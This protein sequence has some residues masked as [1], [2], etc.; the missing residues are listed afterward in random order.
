MNTRLL[1]LEIPVGNKMHKA[2]PLPVIEFPLAEE[3]PTASEES[4]HCQKKSEATAV[5]ITLLSKVK[6]KLDSYEVPKSTTTT[7]TTSGETGTK[8]GRTVT[9]TAED[10][11]KKKNDVKARTTLLLS[12]PDEHQLHFSKYKTARELWAAILKTFGGNEATKKTKKNL[13]KQQYGNFRAEGS[14]TLEQTFTRLQFGSRMA[15]AHYSRS[16]LDTMSLDD[17][18]NHLKVYESEVHKKSEPNYQIMAFISLAKHSS[19]S[20]D[21][22]TACVPTASTNVPTA[23]ASVATISQDTACAYIASQSSGMKISIQGSDVA[24]F[25]KLKVKCF[26][27]HKMGHFTRECRAPRSQDRGRRDN[28]RQGSKA[29]D[30]APKALMSIDGVGWDWSYMANDEKDHALVANEVASTEFALMANTSAESKVFDNSLC[31]KD[32]NKNNDSL[33]SKITDLTDKLFDAKN[34]IYHYKLGLAQ[35]ESRL[36]EYKER[37]VKYCEKIKTLEFRNGSNNECIEILKKKIETLKQEKEGVDGKLAG[38]LTASKNLDNIIKSQRSDKN[39]D[40]LG[41]SVVPPPPAQLY[42]SP[43]DLSWIGLLEFADDT[44]TNYSR[45]S[46]TV[47]STS[48]DDQNINPFLSDTVATP[49]TP[50][51][52]IKFV[53]PKDSQSKSKTDETGTPKKPPFKKRVKKSFTP[54]PVAHRP[55]RPPV[56]PV[57]TNMN[58]A[59][60]NR[61]SFNKQ[62][63]L[64]ANKPFH[65]TSAVRSHYRAPW[66]PTV[67]RNFPPVNRKFY[68]GSRNF[69]TTNRKFPTASR[70]FPT[71][72]SKC[73]TAD[74]GMKGKAINPLACWFWK[75]SQNLSNKGLN[76]N[77]VSVM[78]KKYTYIDTQG[79]LNGCSRHMTGN[80]S[81]LSDFEPFDGGYVSFGQGGCKIT[82]KGTIKTGKLEFENEAREPKGPKSENHQCDNGGEFRNKEMNDFCLQKRIKREFSNARTP[83]QND[84]AE[85]RNRT[86][87]EA[88]KT[89]LANVKLPVT[90]WAEALNTACYVQN[91][92]LVNKSHNKTPYE[93]F[94]GRSPAIGFLKQFSCHDMILNTLENLGKFKEKGDEGYFIRYSMSSKAFRVFNK[95][96][97]RVEENLHVEF[98]EN[99]AIEKG[100]GPNWLFDIDSLTKSMNYVLVDAGTISTNLSGTK[101]ATSQEVKKDA[102]SLR[103]IA[104]PN[105][106]HDALLEFSSS[107][108]QDHC[109]TGVPKG[110]GNPNPTA[111]ISYPPADQMETLIV[112]TLIPTVSL[113]V[114]STYSTDSQEPSSDAR[115][116]SKRV[117]NQEET[118]SLDNILSL[119]NRFEDILGVTIN[120]DESNGVE[121]DISN[122]ETAIIASPTPTLR[123]YKDHPKSHLIG[124]LDTPIQTRNKSKEVEEQSFIS[125]IHQKTDPALLHF[126][127]C[128]E[129]LPLWGTIDQTLFIIRQRGDFI[130]VQVYV[131]EIIF[132]SSNPQLC[133]EFKALM[134]EKFQMS[135]MG[136]L[137]FFLSL[138]VLQKKDGI[139]LSQDKHQVTPKECHLYA[140]KRIF[141]Y[142]KGHPK[143]GLWYPKESPFDLVAYS[144]SE[145][146]GATQDRKSTTRGCQ[147]LRRRLSMPC[148]V[149]S[150]EFSISILRF[151]TI[152]AR[153][154]FCDYHNMVAIL[155]KSEY[156][157][158]FHPMVDFIEASPLRTITESSLRRNLKLQDEEGISSLPDTELFEN[159]TLMGYNI[160]PNQKFT[161]QKASRVTSPAADEGSMQQMI[162]ELMALCTSLQRQHSKLLAKFQA[163]EMEINM[164]KERVKLL[165]DRDGVAA[166]RSRDDALIKGR[167][168][169]EGEAAAERI[170]NDSEEMATVLTSMDAAIV[171]VGGIADVPTS[172]GS[173]PTASPPADEVPT[174]SDVVPTASPVV[175]TATVVTPDRRRKEEVT[176]EAKSSDEV[177][178]EKVKEIMQLVPIEDVYV[179][180]LQVKHPIINWMVY[181]EG[182]RSY[183]KITRLGGSST[184]YQFFIDLLKHLDREDLNQLWRLVK[185]T[186]SNR[187]PTSD[188]EMEL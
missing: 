151:N 125:T 101:D 84:V 16:D 37:E 35:V 110:S 161:L 169:D 145:Y 146:G 81:Y 152:M 9:L 72:S 142:L 97:R 94:N 126:Y 108:P 154:Q 10:I 128:E 48:G 163:Q 5:K 138:Q 85:R 141:R 175:A 107:K 23:S 6:K 46:P 90:F 132:G 135:A 26:N 187:P 160:S 140:V 17:L 8:S 180:A 144:D 181:H 123:I 176:G 31:S 83:Q 111:S 80:I 119:T 58:G 118:P 32:Y 112:E 127:G 88:T 36:V 117:A 57:R 61:T 25:D 100:V 65:K 124:P 33:N 34:M 149:L 183:W 134:H 59:R 39:K 42:S 172:S 14:E 60:P 91:R 2:F 121:A 159:L 87:I 148:E 139:F 115:L 174:G 41:Y 157:I 167:S 120:S 15:N 102:S 99:K 109:S 20:E 47:E 69:P 75:P 114:P 63:H 137:N 54:K 178:E 165:E 7:D 12:L 67:N 29:E 38:L 24:G 52:F 104:L 164:L 150:R 50:K 44:V 177:P 43:K 78:F 130:L 182:Q 4:C 166:Q 122:M 56:R 21:G 62:A 49:I 27:F 185:E 76:N 113:P 158:D 147:F 98:L 153:L 188:K 92:V 95:R 96:T 53:K 45:P 3:L 136:E 103:Y 171:L 64:Y 106:A 77:S 30:Q 170:S 55:Y 70:K 168:L 82:G 73:S 86:L 19:G 1:P 133:R 129:C 173:I 184:S 40:G 162:S 131:D 155:E 51:P 116:I 105:W 74:M 11:Q 71:G 13:L 79:R 66:V 18:Y 89:M 179:E 93:L 186:L 156:N 28:Y 68:T 143:L 22:N